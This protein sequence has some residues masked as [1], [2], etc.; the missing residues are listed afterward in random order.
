ML[1]V[2]GD[3]FDTNGHGCYSII[4]PTNMQ[5]KNDG[6]LV[7]GAGVAKQAAINCPSLPRIWGKYYANINSKTE[8]ERDKVNFCTWHEPGYALVKY[9]ISFPTKYDWR[10]KSDLALIRRSALDLNDMVDDMLNYPRSYGLMSTDKF[11]LPCV[12]A[13]L[14][15]LPWQEVKAMLSIYLDDKFVVVY[16]KG[17]GS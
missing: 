17:K 13:G 4:I 6:W 2:A 15:G 14:G 12:G 3:L 9:Y 8:D 10:D 5:V 11:A 7:M 16:P 1:E